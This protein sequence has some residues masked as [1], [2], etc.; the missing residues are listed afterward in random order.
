VVDY[1]VQSEWFPGLP[2]IGEMDL[3]DVVVTLRAVGDHQ[4]ADSIQA[5][6]DAAALQ[7]NQ[8]RGH[9]LG[10]KE[11]DQPRKPSRLWPFGDKPWQ[12][13][14]HTVGY[15]R[16]PTPGAR[17]IDIASV[18]EVSPVRRLVGQRI[19]ITLDHLRIASYPGRGLHH[20]LVH[21][22]ALNATGPNRREPVRFNSVFRGQEGQ[23]AAVRGHPI[24]VGLTVPEEG[25]SLRCRTI[26]VRND[27]DERLLAFL[28]SETFQVGLKIVR[29]GS[30]AVALFS[31]MA[32]A[33][34]RAVAGNHSN[35]SV[36]DLHLGFDYT[37][38]TAGMSLAEGNYVA[39][40]TPDRNRTS[41]SWR[42]WKYDQSTS[43][44]VRRNGTKQ[45][46]PYNYIMF[47]VGRARSLR[48]RP[49]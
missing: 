27:Q 42:D 30:S 28:S 32:Y 48:R 39:V 31:E 22:S 8:P 44:I 26:N 16:P 19:N 6:I 11:S 12:Y 7:P 10:D 37:G 38:L 29:A 15:I 40:Q 3:P 41:W 18:D 20:V 5:L 45:L 36:Q 25:F 47:G 43:Q 35:V 33:L 4:T 34:A 46:I 14:S 21:V 9:L 13:T 17:T 24:L 49:S 1:M 2:T 23:S